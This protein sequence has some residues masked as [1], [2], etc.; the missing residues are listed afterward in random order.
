MTNSKRLKINPIGPVGSSIA[1]RTLQASMKPGSVNGQQVVFV[2]HFI[3]FD[4]MAL[5]VVLLSNNAAALIR[6]AAIIGCSLI[7]VGE[8]TLIPN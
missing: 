6:H 8:S 5:A 4:S 3:S 7:E 2:L 1:D